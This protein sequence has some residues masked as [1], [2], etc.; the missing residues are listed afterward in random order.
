MIGLEGSSS[1]AIMSTSTKITRS[2]T[3]KQK[4]TSSKRFLQTFEHLRDDVDGPSTSTTSA[5]PAAKEKKK[6]KPALTDD[7]PSTSALPAPKKKRK[8]AK[9]TS[10]TL[11]RAIQVINCQKCGDLGHTSVVCT[12]SS[13]NPKPPPLFCHQCELTYSY[14][15]SSKMTTEKSL[16]SAHRLEATEK[17]ARKEKAALLMSKICSLTEKGT[18]LPTALR[19]MGMDEN[20][21]NRMKIKFDL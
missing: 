12:G 1:V 7:L 2:R 5:L 18:P 9:K 20:K 19:L 4:R 15:S 3:V 13:R 8:A 21:F 17:T 16:C 14:K 10:S 6:R 11:S